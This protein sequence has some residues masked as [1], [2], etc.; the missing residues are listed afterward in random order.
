MN[1]QLHIASASCEGKTNPLGVALTGFRFGW[2]LSS[3]ENDQYQTAYQLV[4]A[5]S[6]DKLN[7][8]NYD[9]YNSSVV[10]SRQSTMVL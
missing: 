8:G 3:K 5:S 10:K 4:V 1:A 7:A 2:E 6:P 9:I